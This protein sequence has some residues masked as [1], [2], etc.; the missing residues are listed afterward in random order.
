[1]HRRPPL[2]SA[3]AALAALSGL[4][5]AQQPV[6]SYL[7]FELQ[8]RS[9]IVDGFNLPALSSFNSK[10]P[11]LND[12]GTLA[13]VLITVGAGD[14][15]LFVGSGGTGSV[16]YSAPMDRFLS[17]PSIDPAGNVAFDQFDVLSDGIFVYDAG[18]GTTGL[19][20]PPAGFATVTGTELTPS[21]ALG[22]RAS[23]LGGPRS[24][25]LADGGVNTT[26]VAEGGGVAFLF[27][28]ATNAS[29]Q[30]AGKVRLGSTAGSA[31]DELRRYDGF[32]SFTLVASDADADAGSPFASFDNS[33]ALTDD[34]R[35]AFIAGTTGGD[36]GVFLTDG[37]NVITIATEN[38]SADVSDI[39]F[40]APAA[41]SGGLVAFRGTDAA[42]LD[43]VFVG[44]GTEL[45]RVIGE[46]DLVSTDLGLGRIDQHDSSVTFG[47]ALA[48]NASGDLAFN[49]SLTPAND[50]QVEWGSGMF[51]GYAAGPAGVPTLPPWGL[52]LLAGALAAAGAKR[53]RSRSA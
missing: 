9:N 14:A 25:V 24:W 51:V 40:F 42:G 10:T 49:A 41:N 46:H 48:I 29:G 3:L 32:G 31:P 26:F 47:G 53:L 39:S 34:G 23:G 11:A 20:V 36:R 19:V 30:I 8:A 21:G 13:F 17:D 44:N 5:S 37:T 2:Y 12:A 1:M 15:G 16:V 45:V 18:T 27:T 6:P 33:V 52:F 28:P 7:Q 43:A 4:A 35:V 22:F 50:D 38:T